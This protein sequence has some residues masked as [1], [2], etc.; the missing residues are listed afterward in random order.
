MYTLNKDQ[1]ASVEDLVSKLDDSLIKGRIEKWVSEV[2]PD[3]RVSGE[4]ME[5]FQSFAIHLPNEF[6]NL[7]LYFVTCFKNGITPEIETK[8]KPSKTKKSGK[9]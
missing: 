8:S 1:I 3:G 2:L 9:K 6:Q 5:Q 4:K 7:P